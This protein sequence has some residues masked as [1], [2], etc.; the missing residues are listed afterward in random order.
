M[1]IVNCKACNKEF[2]IP[3]H[4]IRPNGNSCSYKCNGATLYKKV[5]KTCLHCGAD[6]SVHPHKIRDG[7]GKF[8]SKECGISFKR[9]AF[10]GKKIGK[11]TVIRFS[12][13]GPY[14][15]LRNG[16]FFECLCDCGGTKIVLGGSLQSNKVTSCGCKPCRW[17]STVGNAAFN[18]FYNG[19]KAKSNEREIPF[20]LTKEEFLKITSMD[21]N[22]CGSEP[23]VRDLKV[24]KRLNGQYPC[25]G[26]DRIDSDLGYTMN[27]VTPCCTI[28]NTMKMALSE[29]DF[30]SHIEKIHIHQQNKKLEFPP[31]YLTVIS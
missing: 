11:L 17:N 30:L 26:I 24:T 22:Y 14:N 18:I 4:Q 13:L 21:C 29:G 25:N 5:N 12:H 10:I 28:C 3:K 16:S 9:D 2:D 1:P 23:V 27:N 8:C 20:N 31:S 6:F 7:R 19:Y 15:E